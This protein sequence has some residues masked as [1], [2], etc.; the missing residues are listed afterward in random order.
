[1]GALSTLSSQ[2]RISPDWKEEVNQ[3][4]AAHKNRKP[5]ALVVAASAVPERHTPN[6]RA[7]AAAARVA[8]RFANAPSYGD[9]IENEARAA[10]RAAEAA[11]RAA[12]QAQAA[13]E[14]MLAGLQAAK[15]AQPG[16]QFDEDVE[17]PAEQDE[18]SAFEQEYVQPAAGAVEFEV[19]ERSRQQEERT[20][21]EV[22]WEPDAP[23]NR[24]E[25]A[26]SSVRIE[27]PEWRESEGFAG[28]G[29]IEIVE[30]DQPIPAN[31]IQFPREIVA[32]RKVRPRR[33]EG[34]F[35]EQE[36]PGS[37]LSIFEVTPDAI[38][39]DP[40]A[41]DT[42]NPSAAPSWM[43]PEWSGMELGRQPANRIQDEIASYEYA[44]ESIT[45]RQFD[46]APL[47]LRLMSVVVDTS[48]VLAAFLVFAYEILSRMSGF[49]GLRAAEIGATG[50]L[51]LVSALYVTL[52]YYFGEATP[53]MRYAHIALITF[54]G[55]A[56]VRAERLH[57]LV[58]VLLSVLP[59]GVGVLWSIFDENHLSWH[60]RLSRTYLRSY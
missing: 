24:A 49:V 56:P 43:N 17:L 7:S 46:Q 47:T 26:A 41:A 9:V 10:V 57:R 48:L 29:A 2:A 52:F 18:E 60:D 53:G 14:S 21:Y 35:A 11:S 44:P 8:A 34:P 19:S 58:A 28:E 39:T 37:Q 59:V 1:M 50:G 12:L 3:R 31:L 20:S 16:W 27:S 42:M 4:L 54:D 6:D 32:T 23:M 38:S 40:A 51:M 15:A 45:D 33:A 13:A 55:H 30:G 22:R 25:T 5:A 36:E